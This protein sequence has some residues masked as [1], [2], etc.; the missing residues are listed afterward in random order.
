MVT[1]ALIAAGTAAVGLTAP[2]PAAA[3]T[4]ATPSSANPAAA[5]AAALAEAKSSGQ[6]VD[7][8]ALT[9]PTETV[10]ADPTGS[11]T[12][13]QSVY[14]TRV[15]RNNGWVPVDATLQTASDG[16]LVPAAVPSGIALSGGGT[17]T[18]LA[19]LTSYG[20]RLAI[21]WPGTL[22]KPA[23][24]GATATYA[25]VFPGVDLK[26]TVSPL[27]GMSEVLVVKSAEAAANPKLS[28][29]ELGTSTSGLK[30][31]GD[32]N[33]NLEAKDPTGAAFF[34]SPAAMM[35]DSSTTADG[36]AAAPMTRSA[37]ADG[38][39]A[40]PTAPPA[41]STAQ[42]PGAGAQTGQVDTEVSAGKLT[43]TPD[44]SVLRGAS[45][46]YPVYIDPDW[47]PDYASAPEQG[48][49]EI[50]QGCPDGNHLNSTTTPYNTPGVGQNG[51]SGCIGI[52]EAY[53][54]FKVDAR[55]WNSSVK[56]TAATFKATELYAANLDCSYT[57]NVQVK[58]SNTISTATTWNNR[59]SLSTLQDT[60]AF[61]STCTSNPSQGFDVSD[62]LSKAA[63]GRWQSVAFGM[64]ASDETNKLN[65][66]RF[67]NNPTITVQ[68]DSVPSVSSATTSPSTVC[69][70]GTTIGHTVTALDAYVTDAD[71]GAPLQAKFAVIG[72]D[73]T[74]K[75][76]YPVGGTAAKTYEPATTVTGYGTVV[77]SLGYL[78]SGTY[79]WT[80]QAD[81]GKYLSTTKACSFKVDATAPGSPHVTSPVFDNGGTA[82]ERT[83]AEFDFDPPTDAAGH[84]ATDIAY[85]AYNW[86]TPP[87]SVNPR[88]TLPAA[89]GGATTKVTL[90][91]G[92]YL[93]NILYYYAVDTAGN[94]SKAD[95]YD[96]NTEPPLDADATGDLSGDGHPDLVVPGPNGNVRLYQGDGQGGLTSALDI[97]TGGG[98]TGAKIAVGG[99]RMYGEQDVLAVTR[100]GQAHIYFGNGDAE[101]LP[102]FAPTVDEVPVVPPQ[103][104]LLSSDT[105]FT[106]A[107]VSEIVAA[108]DAQGDQPSLWVVTTDGILW[109]V[110]ATNAIGTFD[111]PVQ[112]ATGW[113]S[114]TLTYAGMINGF[115]AL[116]AR[117]SV[118]GELDLYQGSD[119][120][121]AGSPTSAKTVASAS[122]WTGAAHPQ[123]FFAG[124]N[125]SGAPALWGTDSQATHNVLYYP[126]GS[127]IGSLG[128][129]VREQT[130]NP[131][132]DF[133]GDGQADIVAQ[134][135]DGT[136][137]M[138]T[139]E[140]GGQ[141][142]SGA[143]I[144]DSGW[145]T[146]TSMVSGDFTGDGTSDVVT[147]WN[148]GTLHRYDG[149][150]TGALNLQVPLFPGVTSWGIVR[151]L[152]AG[153][154]NGDGAADLVGVWND[155]TLHLYTNTGQ[156]TFNQP[157][158]MWPTNSSWDGMTLLSGGDFN[159]DGN[160]DILAVQGSNGALRLYKGDGN[161]HL[162]TPVTTGTLNWTGIRDI[163]PGDFS[164]D[165]K[166]DLAV[167]MGSGALHLFTGNGV[168]AFTDTGAMWPNTTWLTIKLAT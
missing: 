68:Y 147:I 29:L 58:L 117:D 23:M 125:A 135:S 93:H 49:D 77:W 152:T 13:T 97:S 50:Q 105:S 60:K 45:T 89:A 104:A 83:P 153:D 59:P 11:L 61:G 123:M 157:V 167:I 47:N 30:V 156:G 88:L 136:L 22:P 141:L 154:F 110:P 162:A 96:F 94:E 112:V 14:P 146:V 20:K 131:S 142:T 52:E 128:S 1:S 38:T 74:G 48:Y 24:S 26:V 72:K 108:D 148:D 103:D 19:T 126:A 133:T 143:K 91:P 40:T 65:F 10:A 57:S 81:D 121:T 132:D 168:G 71:T 84:P 37:Q 166:A 127:S 16:S 116:W 18:P 134:W 39:D 102:S 115:P 34:T 119:N 165:G 79:T 76:V 41:P 140:G 53:F 5:T 43:L 106:W 8:P 4:A 145:N 35:W 73:A 64:V 54:Q 99:F 159:G 63:V 118:T 56:I 27:G 109:W 75:I 3:S 86:G 139:G 15:K 129:S 33:G 87:A 130:L 113:Q 85:Y 138:Y 9:T 62:A 160:G 107:Q 55:L 78:P 122:G 161:S 120:I 114:K 17:T 163:I 36:T 82:P 46:H 28:S 32:T 25:E 44:S 7:I 90:T 150:G 155:G 42:G 158:S 51:Y 21:T 101:P 67:A 2:T 80:V 100:N 66:R 98:F 137:H 144:W 95:H 92:G 6:T 69:S 151:E 12:L 70:G 124:A 149:T 31:S 164:G 111:T